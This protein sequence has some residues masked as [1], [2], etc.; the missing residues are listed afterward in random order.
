MIRTPNNE[1]QRMENRKVRA[2]TE[3]EFAELERLWHRRLPLTQ[4]Q[5]RRRQK[6]MKLDMPTP[7]YPDQDVVEWIAELQGHVLVS[8]AE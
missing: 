7:S 2:M 5:Q 4:R 6:L 1:D 3:K 8:T